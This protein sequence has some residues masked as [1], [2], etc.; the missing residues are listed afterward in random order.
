MIGGVCSMARNNFSKPTK[1]D[2]LRRSG[3]RCE[4]VGAWYGLPEGKRCMADLSYGVQY[5]HIIL[6]ANSHDNNLANCAAV[7]VKCHGFKTAKHDTPLAAKTLRQQDKAR[8]IVDAP[9]MRGAPFP[10]SPKAARRQAKDSL[11]YRSMFGSA[12]DRP[13]FNPEIQDGDHE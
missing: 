3:M 9:K 7:C 2:A 1:R 13:S 6:D 12:L 10:T 11:P 5:D 4:A 8:R